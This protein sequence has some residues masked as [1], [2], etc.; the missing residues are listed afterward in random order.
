[1]KIIHSISEIQQLSRDLAQEGKRI[2][3]VPTMGFL[4]EGH[5]SLVNVAKQHS[6]VVVMSIFVNPTQFGPNEDYD[7]Y[8]RDAERDQKLAAER[9]VDYLWMPEV[10]QMYPKGEQTKVVVTELTRGLCGPFR[11]GHFMGVTT[12]VA[13]LFSALQ[14]Q[15]A[16][17]GEKDY[18]QLQVI[19]RM[20]KDLL[21]PIEIIGV[22]TL[23]DEDGL[24]KSSRNVYL[25]EEERKQVLYISQAIKAVQQAVK[26]GEK[27]VQKLLSLGKDILAQAPD[28]QLE[29]LEIVD[30]EN[31]QKLEV[32]QRPARVLIAAY[33]NHKRFID[34]GALT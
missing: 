30:A 9:G 21:M 3:F 18:Q 2:G 28:L 34:N 27:Q 14:P 1:M 16:V 5:L 26:K 24:A 10:S 11:P 25:N 8:P 17:F 33:V 6:D 15:I 31:L 29:Y 4:H 12:I 20:A 23:R 7:S 22:P 32:I 13:K 19:R